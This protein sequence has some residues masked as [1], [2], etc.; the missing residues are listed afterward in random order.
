MKASS[1]LLGFIK[2][3]EGCKLTP[4]MDAGG[5]L[6]VG[7][8]HLYQHGETVGPIT[9]QQALDYLAKDLSEAESAV[10]NH[11]EVPIA[12]NQYDA[13]VSLAFNIGSGNFSKSHFLRYF[14]EGKPHLCADTILNWNHVNN[15]VSEGLTRRRNAER[16]MFLTGVY[17]ENV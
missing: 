2:S 17:H 7:I 15:Q 5:R 1:E 16:E 8:G 13:F 9:D 4:Y 14:N 3:W 12:Q 10:T 6:S 11:V